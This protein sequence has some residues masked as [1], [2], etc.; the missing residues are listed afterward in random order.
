MYRIED[1]QDCLEDS[2][3]FKQNKNPRYQLLDSDLIVSNTGLVVN[4]PLVTVENINQTLETSDPDYYDAYNA[5]VNYELGDRIKVVGAKPLD[6]KYYVSILFPNMSNLPVS[7]PA[8]WTK[9]DP[10]SEY[11]RETRQESV[12]EVVEDVMIKKKIHEEIKEVFENV[13]IHKGAGRLTD[14]EIKEGRFVG[15]ELTIL[16][17]D[18]LAAIINRIGLQFDGEEAFN[19]L[20]F[21][22]SRHE[23]IATIPIS[24]TSTHVFDWVTPSEEFKLFYNSDEYET[25]GQFFIGYKES[26]ITGQAIVKKIN[27][28]DRPCTSCNRNEYTDWEKRARYLRVR[29]FYIPESEMINGGMWNI[30][31]TRYVSDTNWGL[32]LDMSMSC[33]LTD[34]LCRSKRMLS[35]A[36]KL[37]LEMNLL[38][39]MV[40]NTRNNEISTQVKNRSRYLKD[41][42]ENTTNLSFEYSRTIK[43]LNFDLTELGSVCFPCSGPRKISRT[44]V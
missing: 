39:G 11:L 23:A 26:D 24:I 20:V 36:I 44:V 27:V 8:H 6:V 18:Q 7:S 34:Y 10:V 43:A 32:N 5:T 17:Q 22:S 29:T 4:N 15:Y 12:N 14:K 28:T 16:G 42:K 3:G 40:V 41:D 25:G 38:E 35:N 19:L 30:E 31:N 2:V 21:H 37:K 1:L 33:D 9:F 13:T